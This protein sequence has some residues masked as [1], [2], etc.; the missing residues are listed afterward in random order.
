MKYHVYVG[1]YTGGNGGNGISLLQLDTREKTLTFVSSWQEAG[2]N[3][4]FLAVARDY[5]FAVSEQ[6]DCGYITSLRRNPATG[7]LSKINS[8]KTEGSAMCHLCLWPDGK[9]LSAS[10]Y[11]SG[12]LLVCRVG[13][14]GRLG[15]VCE[16][17]Q[18]E[19]TG[20]D[21]VGRQEGPHVHST[22]ISPDG[23]Y[24]YAADLGLDQLFCYEIGENGS[25]IL[26]EEDRQIHTPAGT[27]PRHFTFSAD[28]RFLYLMTEMG[29]RLFVYENE[30]G[31][32]K[33]GLIQHMGTLPEGYSG[34]SQGADIHLSRDGRFLYLSNRGAN[35]IGVFAVSGETGLVRPVGQQDCMGDFPR[36]FCITPDDGF[37]LIANQKSG[38]VALC[39]R[40]PENGLMGGKL[41]EVLIPEAVFVCAV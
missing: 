1:S 33:Y 5:V 2:S 15:D 34:F 35:T 37:M 30:D 38:S 6:E 26:A 10:N 39:G 36:N 22:G 13:A 40:S 16:F 27:G 28:G 4:S 23:K 18:H 24:L 31:C 3:P 11:M 17:L 14:D 9:Y 7:E 12:S 19:G 8:I 20:F 41:A 21:S 25:L 29:N 32:G